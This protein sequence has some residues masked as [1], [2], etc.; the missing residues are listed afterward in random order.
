MQ[1]EDVGNNFASG[2]KILRAQFFRYFVSYISHF[3]FYMR[4]FYSISTKIRKV[5]RVRWQKCMN[6]IARARLPF[7][8]KDRGPKDNQFFLSNFYFHAYL[9]T[10]VLRYV[11]DVV[12]KQKKKKKNVKRY[13]ISCLNDFIKSLLLCKIDVYAL[14]TLHCVTVCVCVGIYTI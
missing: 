7:H 1:H 3:F 14:C 4:N 6:S 2:M 13:V 5:V 9:S 12:K 11:V 10:Y 8:A